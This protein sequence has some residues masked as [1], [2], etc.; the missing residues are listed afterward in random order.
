MKP[1][2]DSL[3]GWLPLG[4]GS[5]Q[6]RGLGV[7][8]PPVAWC[9]QDKVAL[10]NE[11]CLAHE[12]GHTR[13]VDHVDEITCP[14]ASEILEAGYDG[15]K[16]TAFPSST[17]DYMKNNA[18][19]GWIS[20]YVWNK[21]LGEPDICP[22]S[23]TSSTSSL[24]EGIALA[25]KAPVTTATTL[26]T[27]VPTVLISGL[28]NSEGSGEIDPMFQTTSVG[29]FASNGTSGDYCLEFLF[30]SASLSQHCFNLSFAELESGKPTDT[31]GFF[32]RL[33]F[34]PTT[35]LILL[36]KGVDILAERS[37]SENAPVVEVSTPTIASPATIEWTATDEDN[38]VLRYIV[39]YTP[40][41]GASYSPLAVQM[42][43]NSFEVDSNRL[44]G[45][46][47]AKIRVL[48]SDGFHTSEAESEAFVVDRKAPEA[49]IIDP[50]NNTL[51]HSD[52]QLILTG[53]GQDLEDGDLTG[54]SLLW[55]SDVEGPI[56]TG[57]RLI[58][59]LDAGALSDGSHE[60]TLAATDSDS[61]VATDTITLTVDPTDVDASCRPNL[62]EVRLSPGD[63]LDIEL[64]YNNDTGDPVQYTSTMVEND[65]GPELDLNISDVPANGDVLIPYSYDTSAF[66]QGRDEILIRITTDETGDATLASCEFVLSVL[67]PPA[68]SI[69]P[70]NQTVQYSDA[71]QD[72][73]ISATDIPEDAL[74]ATTSWSSNGGAFTDEYVSPSMTVMAVSPK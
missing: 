18:N 42:E 6:V 64:S 45:G 23:T 44:A 25:V 17:Y 47:S 21:I 59:D 58:L 29:P 8:S 53:T 11:V 60:I 67:E 19:D 40:D 68:L 27:P 71:I 24:S 34:N 32:F 65:W 52:E 41:G 16:A 22:P 49:S 12:L 72:I 33:K 2:P 35:D 55:T 57:S 39:L 7:N 9:P 74:S 30:G 3:I 26:S 63:I 31:S 69:T 61:N 36:K 37:A 48:A 14:S 20:P 28:V 56:G 13:S 38:D 51:I 4:S 50:D 5:S 10:R 73:V 70:Q 1:E 15:D 43:G 62:E 66:S 54:S 46:E